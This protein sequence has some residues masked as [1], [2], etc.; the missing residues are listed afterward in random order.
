MKALPYSKVEK[1]LSFGSF[2]TLCTAFLL[3][4]FTAHNEQNLLL[5]L[6]LLTFFYI[7]LF[8]FEYFPQT[9]NVVT[10]KKYSNATLKEKDALEHRLRFLVCLTRLL[11][12]AALIVFVLF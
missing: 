10:S 3:Y 1:I 8:L 12:S 2:F 9:T 4:F 5:P 6:I 7:L 11:L